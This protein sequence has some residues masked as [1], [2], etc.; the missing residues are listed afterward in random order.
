MNEIEG[1]S[2]FLYQS[3]ELRLYVFD[4]VMESHFGNL[5][6]LKPLAATMQITLKKCTR[7]AALLLRIWL[8]NISYLLQWFLSCFWWCVS[9]CECNMQW[10]PWTFINSSDLVFFFFISIMPMV[11]HGNFLKEHTKQ[12]YLWKI[13]EVFKYIHYF[14]QHS[15]H[16]DGVALYTFSITHLNDGA[17]KL[18]VVSNFD[19]RLRKLLKDLNVLD[20]WVSKASL[21]GTSLFSIFFVRIWDVML[22]VF[23]F[24]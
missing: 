13:Q 23:K 17:V 21:L 3:T 10:V 14:T 16:I 18:A 9:S 1:P 15:L 2:T 4:R 22:V 5:L 19:S 7:Y 11:M 24:H 8:I 6:C 12:C 20:L